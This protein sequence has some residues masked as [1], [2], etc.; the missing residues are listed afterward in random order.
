M[1]EE[2]TKKLEMTQG[3]I[4]LSFRPFEIRTVRVRLEKEDRADALFA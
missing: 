3:G 4:R 2:E 1:L